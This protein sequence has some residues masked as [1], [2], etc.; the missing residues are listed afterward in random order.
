MSREKLIKKQGLKNPI[1]NQAYF[2]PEKPGQG[3]VR[4]ASYTRRQ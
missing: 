4:G 3:K 2:S 1:R